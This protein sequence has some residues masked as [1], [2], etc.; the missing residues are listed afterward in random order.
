VKRLPSAGRALIERQAVEE[1]RRA[2]ERWPFGHQLRRRVGSWQQ[3]IARDKAKQLKHLNALRDLVKEGRQ[4][5]LSQRWLMHLDRLELELSIIRRWSLLHKRIPA[6]R[7]SEAPF[8]AECHRVMKRH[9]IGPDDVATIIVKKIAP[10]LPKWV[11]TALIGDWKDER[12][13]IKVLA[14]RIRHP[15]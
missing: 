7:P 12:R 3:Q 15:A 10:T 2:V 1:L 11:Q 9:S 6:H 8:R 5:G 13:R 4:E 14:D